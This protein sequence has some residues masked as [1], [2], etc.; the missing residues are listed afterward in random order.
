MKILIYGEAFWRTYT[1]GDN[2]SLI[3]TDSMKNFIQQETL[4]FEGSDLESY[5]RFLAEKVLSI[6]SQAEGA[7]ISASGIP[8]DTVEGS[9]SA[10]TP[11][12][13][14]RAFATIEMSRGQTIPDRASKDSGCCG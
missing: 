1:P 3:A 4:N 2:T 7:Q 14:E 10:F 12:G 6:Y 11:G 5:R 8:Y 13:P 9:T